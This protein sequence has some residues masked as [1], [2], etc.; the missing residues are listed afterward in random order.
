MRLI[1]L[2]NFTILLI[3]RQQIHGQNQINTVQ[4]TIDA[5]E[6]GFTLSHEHIMSNFG[7]EISETAVYDTTKLF[8][9]VIP[10]LR[11]T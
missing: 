11:M 2:I 1:L 8:N 7:K 9:Q 10:Y 6:L 3:A 4:G 5:S